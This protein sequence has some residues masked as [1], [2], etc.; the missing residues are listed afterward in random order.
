MRCGC[1]G[2][3]FFIYDGILSGYYVGSAFRPCQV[4][5]LLVCKELI[6]IS[7]PQRNGG[8]YCFW[9]FTDEATVSS[10]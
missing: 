3:S 6:D 10:M 9:H 2:V 8:V 7:A 1:V 4:S 5:I